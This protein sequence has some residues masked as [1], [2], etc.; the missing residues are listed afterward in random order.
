MEW[1]IA[2]DQ[3]DITQE[4]ILEEVVNETGPHWIEGYAGTGKT[5]VLTHA[6]KRLRAK[7]KHASLCFVTYTHALKDLVASGLD[8]DNIDI[9]TVDSFVGQTE[10]YDWAFIDEVQDITE[11]KIAKIKKLAKHTIWA[12]DPAQ[13]LYHQRVQQGDLPAVLGTKSLKLKHI[14]R[15]SQKTYEIA[16]TIYPWAKVM[17]GALVS[18]DDDV[19]V[20]LIAAMTQAKEVAWVWKKAKIVSTVGKPSAVLFPTHAEIYDFACAVAKSEGKPNPPPRVEKGRITDYSAFNNHFQ[21]NRIALRFL[22]SNNGDLPESDTKSICYLMTYKSAKGLDFNSV[23]LP[24]LT[25]D[26]LFEDGK[27]LKFSSDEWQRKYFFVGLTRSRRDLF[28][29]YHGLPHPFLKEMPKE[30][31]EFEKI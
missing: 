18:A 24:G 25:E 16:S 19:D 30:R 27:P 13:S 5:I 1:M 12:G 7:N 6:V 26:I 21:K 17:R 31:Y 20:H 4:A 8:D 10:K 29:S 14:Y 15:L 23:F 2:L 3:F 11:E 9:F 22:G 28:M